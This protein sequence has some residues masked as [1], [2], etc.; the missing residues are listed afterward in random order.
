VNTIAISATFSK[1]INP[2]T[3]TPTTFTLFNITTGLPV[4]GTVTVNADG[5]VATFLPTP[6]ISPA[7]SLLPN[8]TFIATITTTVQDLAGNHLASNFSWTFATGASEDL[9]A[10]T[11]T[12]TSPK[13]GATAVPTNELFT[14]TFTEPVLASSVSTSTFTLTN[15]ATGLPVPGTVSFNGTTVATFAP[16]GLLAP[17]TV[18]TATITTGVKDLAGNSLPGDNVFS[19]TT[20]TTPDT[21]RPTVSTALPFNNAINVPVNTQIIVTF[22]KPVSVATVNA[23]T[24]IL[25]SAAGQEPG[26]FLFDTSGTTAT[27]TP[28]NQLKGTTTFTTTITTGVTDQAGNHLLTNFTDTF[29]TA[30]D[31]VAPTVLS[32]IPAN[33]GTN[34]PLTKPVISVTFDEPMDPRTINSTTITLTSA[35]TPGFVPANVF[36]SLDGRTAQV[37]P[38]SPFIFAGDTITATISSGATDLAGNRLTPFSWSFRTGP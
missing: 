2:A 36:L 30:S 3:I 27:F 33:G 19:F 17:S 25:N 15:N 13:T 16:T 21:T 23:A 4:V 5:T 31:N 18:Y 10:P 12:L 22:S 20:G 14:V 34:V 8:A 1:A 38:L 9:T 11:I 37:V 35:L 7:T 26:T 6:P 32:T 28:T 29:T 24:F